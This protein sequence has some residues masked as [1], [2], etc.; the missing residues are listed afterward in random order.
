MNLEGD[1]DMNTNV[2]V[3]SLLRDST[4]KIFEGNN[5]TRLQCSIVLF[6]LC[7]LNSVPNI[8]VDALLT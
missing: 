3:E 5:L 8:F 7:S 1:V 2:N 4:E 6:F